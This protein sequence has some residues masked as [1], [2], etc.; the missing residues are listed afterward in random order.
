MK[1]HIESLM[2]ITSFFAFGLAMLFIVGTLT[3][4][5]ETLGK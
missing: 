3:L 1:H 4:A 5:I 2:I